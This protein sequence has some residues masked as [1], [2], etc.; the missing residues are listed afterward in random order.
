MKLLESLTWDIVYIL[1]TYRWLISG[2]FFILII[3][4]IFKKKF[5]I[6][7]PILINFILIG[8]IALFPTIFG[9]SSMKVLPFGIDE[10]VQDQLA[11]QWGLKIFVSKARNVIQEKE[12]HIHWRPDYIDLAWD[13]A[14]VGMIRYS[15]DPPKTIGDIVVLESPTTPFPFELDNKSFSW[16]SWRPDFYFGTDQELILKKLSLKEFKFITFISTIWILCCTIY[17][18][19]NVKLKKHITAYNI[20]SLCTVAIIPILLISIALTYVKKIYVAPEATINLLSKAKT[21]NILNELLI[22]SKKCA[23]YKNFQLSKSH[24]YNIFISNKTFLRTNYIRINISPFQY[25]FFAKKLDDIVH[26]K[27][28]KINQITTNIY[29]G[30]YNKY[31]KENSKTIFFIY[32]TIGIQLLIISIGIIF[33][34]RF[35]R[36]S[37]DKIW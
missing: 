28:M 14:Y 7:F 26:S 19:W 2:T 4:C 1:Y 25:V 31:I 20:V 34:V 16:T 15:K 13:G 23:Y 6:S 9:Y 21:Q 36:N 37:Q 27:A 35:L 17:S 3:F 11:S 10:F 32:G 30:Y 18:L 24:K 33:L 29:Y 8:G 12:E 22:N 5:W